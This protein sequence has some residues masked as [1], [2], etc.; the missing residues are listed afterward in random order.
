[1]TFYPKLRQKEKEARR[2]DSNLGLTGYEPV[3]LPPE[4]R[5]DQY[6]QRF[7]FSVL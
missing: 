4:L 5:R 7:Y 6:I 1:M 3:A 2:E